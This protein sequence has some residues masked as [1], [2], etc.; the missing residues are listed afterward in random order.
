MGGWSKY[1]HESSSLVTERSSWT[2]I[3]VLDCYSM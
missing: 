2:F 3:S 1:E